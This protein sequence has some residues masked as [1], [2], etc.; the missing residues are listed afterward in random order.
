MPIAWPARAQ[1]NAVLEFGCVCR[2]V[3]LSWNGPAVHLLR[4]QLCHCFTWYSIFNCWIESYTFKMELNSI[5]QPVAGWRLVSGICGDFTMLA[6]IEFWRSA[7]SSQLWR[8]PNLPYSHSV[9]HSS[10]SC[11]GTRRCPLPLNHPRDLPRTIGTIITLSRRW[12]SSVWATFSVRSSM[13]HVRV[14]H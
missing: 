1:I 12:L 4:F 8:Q 13:A 9:P 14:S 3:C 7:C 6:N 5:H 10:S 11:T 2:H